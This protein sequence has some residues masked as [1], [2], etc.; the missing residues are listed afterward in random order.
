VPTV[1]SGLLLQGKAES[2][3]YAPK[4]IYKKQPWKGEETRNLERV[5]FP[6]D[7]HCSLLVIHHFYT[8]GLPL[9]LRL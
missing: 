8:F 6:T 2:L 1:E 7:F 5:S 9:A 3:M 4:E